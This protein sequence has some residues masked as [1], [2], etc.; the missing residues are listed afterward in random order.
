M[1]TYPDYLGT[2]I[3][4]YVLFIRNYIGILPIC[5]YLTI[6]TYLYYVDMYIDNI[7]TFVHVLTYTY[8]YYTYLTCIMCV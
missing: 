5:M 7:L 2:Y 3:R 1:Y 4:V 8:T 6:H